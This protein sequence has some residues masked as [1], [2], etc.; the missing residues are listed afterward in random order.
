M[1]MHLGSNF[2]V[3]REDVGEE[4]EA[5]SVHPWYQG[6]E[7]P[8]VEGLIFRLPVFLSDP[9]TFAFQTGLPPCNTTTAKSSCQLPLYLVICPNRNTNLI[10]LLAIIIHTRLRSRQ[11]QQ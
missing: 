9:L 6:Y 7:Q 3:A 11:L 1:D 5:W 4:E 8:T 10:F 2:N